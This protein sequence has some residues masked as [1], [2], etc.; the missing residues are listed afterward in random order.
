MLR[1]PYRTSWPRVSDVARQPCVAHV[2]LHIFDRA[3]MP[4]R[5]GARLGRR[6]AG[7]DVLL[8]EHVDVKCELAVQIL[9]QAARAG[10]AN[11]AAS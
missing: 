7:A 9:L 3:E 6:H 4:Q 2:I 8:G 10:R 1:R 5:R 11:R